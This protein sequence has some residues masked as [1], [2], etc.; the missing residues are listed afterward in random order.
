MKNDIQISSGKSFFSKGSLRLGWALS[1][2]AILTL[3]SVAAA[4]DLT[5]DAMRVDYRYPST[6]LSNIYAGSTLAFTVATGG[7]NFTQTVTSAY[8]QLKLAVGITGDTIRISGF[9]WDSTA[10]GTTL[11]TSGGPGITFN[12]LVFTDESR[13]LSGA[14]I[15]PATTLPGLDTSRVLVLGQQLFINFMGLKYTVGQSVVVLHVQAIPPAPPVIGS[16][17]QSQ[18]NAGGSATS[19][20]AILTISKVRLGEKDDGP[21]ASEDSGQ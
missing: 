20:V 4:V 8:G 17:P 1:G 19:S 5:G 16:G 12:G 2:M 13:Q 14:T 10:I 9:Q 18:T 15:D 11:G 6:D 3:A 7:T 21:Y